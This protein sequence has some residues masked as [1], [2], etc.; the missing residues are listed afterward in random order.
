MHVCLA[1]VLQPGHQERLDL[2]QEEACNWMMFVR[3]AQ[4]SQESN[5]AA[6][7][8]QDHIYYIATK[9]EWSLILFL[10]LLYLF[11]FQFIWFLF[12]V[13]RIYLGWL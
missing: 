13:C 5:L 4:T 7:Q 12:V 6:Y 10:F 1:Q 2:T 3:P 8:L 11:H 9:V